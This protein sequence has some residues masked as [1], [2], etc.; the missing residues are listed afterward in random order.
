[1]HA[2]CCRQ[3]KTPT[4]Y[5]GLGI[6]HLLLVFVFSAGPF[7]SPCFHHSL[8]SLAVPFLSPWHLRS[9]L[10]FLLIFKNITMQGI[11]FLLWLIAA[12]ILV[13]NA[14]LGHSHRREANAPELGVLFQGNQQFKEKMQTES[15][16]LLAD[17]TENGQ[18]K[19]AC[20]C[21]LRQLDQNV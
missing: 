10:S 21:L 12:P 9:F 16:T 17:L 13:T 5:T 14:H 20:I 8:V 4:A 6:F 1:M 15:P 18:G 7:Y 11:S 3:Y 19:L 2:E